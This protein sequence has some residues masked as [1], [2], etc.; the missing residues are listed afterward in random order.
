[1]GDLLFSR[2]P[3]SFNFIIPVLSHLLYVPIYMDRRKLQNITKT[4]NLLCKVCGPVVNLSSFKARTL[5]AL[6]AGDNEH[7]K[8]NYLL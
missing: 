4:L 1:M 6:V 7:D 8:L 3:M 5:P 2:I